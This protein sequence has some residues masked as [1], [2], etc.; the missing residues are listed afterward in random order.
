MNELDLHL[1]FL[2]F[3]GAHAG[4]PELALH[5]IQALLLD[6]S[7]CEHRVAFLKQLA[8][9][10]RELSVT[11]DIAPVDSFEEDIRL[12]G[13]FGAIEAV[14]RGYLAP[15]RLGLLTWHPDALW[16]AHLALT[17]IEPFADSE[18]SD[19]ELPTRVAGFDGGVVWAQVGEEAL[20][21]FFW[22]NGSD[23]EWGRSCVLDDEDEPVYLAPGQQETDLLFW[24]R[25]PQ[26]VPLKVRRA[27]GYDRLTLEPQQ[28]GEQIKYM[29]VAEYCDDPQER[30]EILQHFEQR[31]RGEAQASAA[32]R[33]TLQPDWYEPVAASLTE[34]RALGRAPETAPPT[35]KLAPPEEARAVPV[36]DPDGQPTGETVRVR[37]IQPLKVN[38]EGQLYAHLELPDWPAR[39]AGSVQFMV[40]GVIVGA[41]VIERQEVRLLVL[42]NP[43]DPMCLGTWH[44]RVIKTGSAKLSQ[45]EPIVCAFG[46]RTAWAGPQDAQ[47]RSL[48]WASSRC[49]GMMM[50]QSVSISVSQLQAGLSQH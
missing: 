37:I 25:T 13:R 27:S 22:K 39:Q 30:K 5:Q 44:I 33:A 26:T 17:S 47:L 29:A 6:A 2:D 11:T 38:D 45:Q 46:D 50:S 16:G 41:A 42:E 14:R 21:L 23:S 1:I 43:V 20:V 35:E 31:I 4:D 8:A 9:S 48:A 3:S 15:E 12:I 18:P 28:Y 10:T 40:A 7:L 24:G 49:N 32:K 34:V 36:F 19:A